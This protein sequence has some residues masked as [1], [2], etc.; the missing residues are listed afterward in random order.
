V[1]NEK[2][3][4]RPRQTDAEYAR[5]ETAIE[6]LSRSHLTHPDQL[7]EQLRTIS[8]VVAR[9]LEVERVGVWRTDQRRATLHC[10]ELFERSIDLHSRGFEL[11]GD[12]CR[13]FI[14]AV[15]AADVV[16]AANVSRDP[17]T[18]V[19]A[20]VYFEPIGVVSAI[21]LPI[22]EKGEIVGVLCCEHVG[23]YRTW[24]HE[25]QTFA[26]AVANLLSSLF[27]QVERQRLEEQLR[28]AQKLED[29]GRLAG[30]IAHDFNN[31]LTVI[32]GKAGLIAEDE[33][34]PEDLRV[35]ANEIV[36]SGERAAT[37]TRQLLAFSRRQ[38]INKRDVDL[39]TVIGGLSRMLG[40]LL[41]ATMT[42]ETS[43]APEP[44]RVR[45]D[46]GMMDQVILNLAI[47]AR[48]AMPRGG[49]LSIETSIVDVGVPAA[50]R[51]G[52]P[53]G[54]Y[55]CLKVADTGSGISPEHLPHIFEPFFTTKDVGKGTGLGL[56][57]IYGIVQHHHGWISVESDLDRGTTFTVHLPYRVESVE[58]APVKVAAA[59]FT[60]RGGET[61]LV[62]EDE[63]PVRSLI[64]EALSAYGYV[65]IEAASG[66]RALEAWK[67]RGATVDLL[68]TDIIMPDG[69]NGIDLARSLRA[70]NPQLRVVF[71]SGNPDDIS[72]DELKRHGDTYLAKPFSL[73]VLARHVR[74]RLDG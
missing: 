11:S 59:D 18:S 66:T 49:R 16:A 36:H 58:A 15:E 74:S 44:A 30:G 65:V 10:Q 20:A 5:H 12:A 57:T 3:A 13:S 17:R 68:L 54:R 73:P 55:V 34:L 31:V 69:L 24:S 39:N 50:V 21:A 9:T 2:P 42:I 28:Q 32:L 48:D 45:A 67:E 33:R 47:N 51:V 25:T 70:A 6:T 14:R 46:A 71:I 43:L 72:S 29:I 41:G 35:A 1:L 37:L 23:E 64:V 38:P 63:E 19:F 62:V 61:I 22:R 7:P 40:S 60:P 53:A 4:P 56:A 8:A 27:A 26:V 52:R